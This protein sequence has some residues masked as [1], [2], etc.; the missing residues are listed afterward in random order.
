MP[1]NTNDKRGPPTGV[2]WLILSLLA[3]IGT[4]L[5]LLGAPGALLERW[6]LKRLGVWRETETDD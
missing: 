3:L 1:L 6:A 4:A 5:K 2:F